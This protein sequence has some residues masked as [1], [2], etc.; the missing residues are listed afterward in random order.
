[1]PSNPNKA[2]A[3]AINAFRNR[4]IPLLKEN[5][6]EYQEVYYQLRQL[7]VGDK[8]AHK[9]ILDHINLGYIVREGSFLRGAK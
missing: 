8:D 7:E 2:F 4:I 3:T 5:E 6:I 9:I 1:M